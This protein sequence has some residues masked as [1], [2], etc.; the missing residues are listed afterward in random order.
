MLCSQCEAL[1][2]GYEREFK[3]IWM[4][5]IPPDFTHL[6]TRALAGVISVTVPDY[7]TFK[8]FHLS[9]FWR[10]AVSEGFRIERFSLGRYE[11]QLARMIRNRDPGRAGDFPFL[12][13]LNLDSTGRPVATVSPLAKGRGRFEGHHYY[14]MTYAFCDWTFVVAQPGP[15]WMGDFETQCR[16]EGVLLLLGVPHSQSKSFKLWADIIR[17]L[18]R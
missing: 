3:K 15:T 16:E 11:E 2:S 7:D 10:A 5:T 8:L 18:R 12:G 1:L 14:M 17:D 4:D 9:V 13:V 6:H